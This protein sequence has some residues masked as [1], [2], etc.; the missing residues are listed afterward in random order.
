[1]KVLKEQGSPSI[2]MGL[3]FSTSAFMAGALALADGHRVLWPQSFLA[4]RPCC[5]VTYRQDFSFC[6]LGEQGRI[7]RIFT[8]FLFLLPHPP[9]SHFPCLFFLFLPFLFS[10][11]PTPFS[12]MFGQTPSCCFTNLQNGDPTEGIRNSLRSVGVHLDHRVQYS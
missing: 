2:F 10:L 5:P 7:S 6:I 8:P 3:S 4:V 11:T 12:I 9:H 1:M